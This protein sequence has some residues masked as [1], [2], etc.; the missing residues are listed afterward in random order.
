MRLVRGRFTLAA[1]D[2]LEVLLMPR[3]LP[4][5]RREAP[6]I[7]VSLGQ[8][9]VSCPRQSS[10]RG[11]STWHV[12]AFTATCPKASFKP[13]LRR[14]VR[15][16][17]SRRASTRARAPHP[18]AI[19]RRRARPHHIAGRLQI[20][21]ASWRRPN[22]K[23]S[24]A[25]TA[26]PGGMDFGEHRVLLSAPRRLLEAYRQH[27]PIAILKAPIARPKLEV[28]MVWHGLT[29]EDPVKS[30]CAASSSPSSARRRLFSNSIACRIR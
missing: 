11:Q 22:R 26:S 30:G 7:Q 25:R 6:G 10:P 8:Q 1:T 29:H 24:T 28:R 16:R 2:Y 18:R 21:S 27:F 17:L 12:R 3:L 4:R 9:A 23:S 20:A 19:S 13:S 15:R 5:L 14:R